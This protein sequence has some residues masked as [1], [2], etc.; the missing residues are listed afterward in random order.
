[1]TEPPTVPNAAYI[2]ASK[3]CDVV[4]KGGITSGVVYP[5]AICEL[6]ETY[7]FRSIG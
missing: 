2:K 4:M 5:P 6:A 7:R 1:M 3:N